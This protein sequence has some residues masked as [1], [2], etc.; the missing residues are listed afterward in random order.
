MVIHEMITKNTFEE[1]LP[2][3]LLKKKR[4]QDAL[5]NYVAV[6]LPGRNRG[7]A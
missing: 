4:G 3:I 5:L 6:D 2:D 7:G 1:R